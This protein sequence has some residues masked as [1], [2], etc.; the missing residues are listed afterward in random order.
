MVFKGYWALPGGRVD[1]GETVEQAVLREIKEET[2][3]EVKIM[4]K[5]GE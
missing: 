3:L 5:I 4:K 2:G 1:P